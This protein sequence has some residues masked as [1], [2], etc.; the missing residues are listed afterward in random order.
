MEYLTG[1][2]LVVGCAQAES[3]ELIST[4]TVLGCFSGDVQHLSASSPVRTPWRAEAPR[5][6]TQLGLAMHCRTIW[7]ASFSI[8]HASSCRV[9]GIA[10]VL[11]YGFW[12]SQRTGIWW[13]LPLSSYQCAPSRSL[14][15]GLPPAHSSFY[16][17][18]SPWKKQALHSMFIQSPRL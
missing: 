17:C 4:G 3:I 2:L 13:R 18:L 8:L 16:W 7:F 6:F 5:H 15:T 9:L 1:C 14:P 11:L 10:E 12:K